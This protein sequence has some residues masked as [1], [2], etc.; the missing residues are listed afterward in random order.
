MIC[1]HCDAFLFK[2]ETHSICCNRGSI[3]I[4]CFPEPPP[5]LK[6]L[7]TTQNQDGVVFRKYA[8]QLNNCLALASVYMKNLTAPGSRYQ[9]TVVIQGKTYTLLGPLQGEHNQPPK[10]AQLYVHDS[11]NERILDQ[12]MNILKASSLSDSDVV[13][14]RSIVDQLQVSS[15]RDNEKPVCF[16]N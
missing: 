5:F 10:F 13:I 7:W 11:S 8:R 12:R 14:L 16:I 6:Y 15:L 3:R 2:Q 9:P 4:D 1:P